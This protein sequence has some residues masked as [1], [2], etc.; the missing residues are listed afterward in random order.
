MIK[1][2]YLTTLKS[3]LTFILEQQ[4][5]FTFSLCL[6]TYNL[7][8]KNIETFKLQIENFECHF[9]GILTS[10]LRYMFVP[11]MVLFCLLTCQGH[12]LNSTTKIDELQ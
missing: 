5:A 9:Q 11:S 8:Y 12:H 10:V 1:L 4:Y 3:A 6:N 2:T 7:I